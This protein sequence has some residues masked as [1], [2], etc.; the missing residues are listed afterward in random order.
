MKKSYLIVSL[1]MLMSVLTKAQNEITP[2]LLWKIGRVSEPRVSPDGKHVLFQVRKFDVVANAGQTDIYMVSPDGK[3]LNILANRPIEES[4]AKWR[5]DGLAITFLMPDNNNDMQIWEMNIDG[6]GKKPITSIKGG[7]NNYGYAPNVSKIWW[8]ADIK[9][10]KKPSEMYPDLPKTENARIIDNLMF[11]HW[12]QWDDYAFSHLFI[13]NYRSDSTISTGTDAMFDERWD[14]PTKPFGGDEQI[15]F[16]PDGK[17]LIYTCKKLGGTQYAM[18]TN[19]DIYIYDTKSRNTE[20]LTEGMNGYDLDPVWSADGNKIYWHSMETPGYE[21]DRNRLFVFDVPTKSKM[22]L[23]PN[24]DYNV[25]EIQFS[26]DGKMLYFI[27]PINATRQ[28]FSFDLNPKSK[29]PLTQIT[30][31]QADY[32]ELSVAGS[33][34]STVIV[35]SRTDMTMPSEL[36]NVDAATKKVNR[37]TTITEPIWGNVKKPIVKKRMVKTTDGKEEL[38]WVVYPANFDSTKKYPA[39]LFCQGGPQ[40]VVSQSFSYRWNF[41][42][43]A[44]NDYIVVAPNRRGLPSFGEAWNDEITGD[45]G[46]QAMDDL[47][48]AIDDVAK[49][50]YVNANKLGAVGASFGG[51]SVYWLA[52]HHNKRFKVFISHCGVF[53]LESEFACTEELFFANH[54]LEGPYWNTPTPKSYEQFSPNKFVKNWD[55]P[56]LVIHNEKDF[57]VPLNQGIEAFT[58]A[59]LQKV[60]SRFLYFPDEGHHVVKPQNSIL[61]NRVFFNW[62]DI[63]L[64]VDQ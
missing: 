42:L 19:T 23:L 21:S 3:T 44:A 12:N 38:V 37:I 27:S 51:Y 31:D 6:S 24:F 50:P 28:I 55:T 36:Y 8:S 1:L 54:D 52:G 63:F 58:A 15:G 7:V 32:N 11:R 53:N 62:L 41:S 22:E 30:F 48:S 57:R 39:L 14:A 56:I 25:E 17:Y 29:N 4:S 47:L 9:Y 16:S 18:S 46:G 60:P 49:E 13:A 40:S 35:A 61:W 64:K 34:K 2:E 59:Q 5:P 33:G 43:M 45:W 26:S 20:N 10:G